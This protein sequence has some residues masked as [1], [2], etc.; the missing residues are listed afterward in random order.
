[1]LT[2]SDV[3]PAT[4]PGTGAV[5][6]YYGQAFKALGPRTLARSCPTT[7]SPVRPTYE[8][9]GPPIFF[10]SNN[11]PL[12]TN[13]RTTSNPDLLEDTFTLVSPGVRTTWT[14][15]FEREVPR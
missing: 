1:R 9:A 15:R 12:A 7:D 8:F 2:I 14:W 10:Q 3:V 13:A 6:R 11:S 4:P 5:R